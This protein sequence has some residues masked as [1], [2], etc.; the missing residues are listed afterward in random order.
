MHSNLPHTVS[1]EDIQLRKHILI[2]RSRV[3]AIL[4]KLSTD[5]LQLHSRLHL[6]PVGHTEFLDSLQRLAVAF[7]DGEVALALIDD[8]VAVDLT[9]ETIANFGLAVGRN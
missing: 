7:D 8:G 5:V 2:L 6:H 3:L 4:F 1:R 9:G